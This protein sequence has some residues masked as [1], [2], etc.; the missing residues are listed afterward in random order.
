M[1]FVDLGGEIGKAYC[2][3]S[4]YPYTVHTP[5]L[6]EDNQKIKVTREL[7][8]V[9]IE[10]RWDQKERV[11]FTMKYSLALLWMNCMRENHAQKSI[12]VLKETII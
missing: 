11:N 3:A 9:T 2:P 10:L 5:L 7:G 4:D 1:G 12:L 8:M 6:P